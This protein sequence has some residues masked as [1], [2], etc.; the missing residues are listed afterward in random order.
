[1][2]DTQN[3]LIDVKNN[4]GV[5]LWTAPVQNMSVLLPLSCVCVDGSYFPVFRE[6]KQR[7]TNTY[8][9]VKVK[10]AG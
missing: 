10:L 1:V 9:I 8:L 7:R 5:D 2:P 4:I 3:V 6:I